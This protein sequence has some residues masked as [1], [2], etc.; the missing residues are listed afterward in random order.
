MSGH[1]EVFASSEGGYHFRLLDSAGNPLATSG[2]YPTIRAAA[3]G[4]F[5]VRE[6]A[7]TGLISDKSGD[8]R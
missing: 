5:T 3:A 8:Q 4:I 2:V 7:G 6:I 1:F